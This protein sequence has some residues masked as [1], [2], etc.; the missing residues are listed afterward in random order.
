MTA[1]LTSTGF[2]AK[3]LADILAEVQA[4]QQATIDPALDVSADSVLGQLNAAVAEKL[5]EQWELA[6]SVYR[7]FD[8]DFASGDALDALGALTGARRIDAVATEVTIT[9]GGT[10]GTSLPIGRAISVVGD[11]ALRFES[12]AG[13]TIGG[14]GTVAVIFRATQ[15]G[16]IAI[17]AG[18]SWQIDTPVSGWS[19]ATNALDGVT[20]RDA[21][22]DAAYRA[23]R[24]QLLQTSGTSPVEAIR[25]DLLGVA[26]VTSCTI[27]ENPTDTTD[28]DGVP[29]HAFEAVVSGGADL[30][31]AT[32]LWL[33]KA[34]GIQ[35]YGTTSQVIQDSQGLSHTMRFS[36]PTAVPIY[37]SATVQ[38]DP[39]TF[40]ADGLDMILAALLAQGDAMAVGADVIYAAQYSPIFSVPGV[41]DVTLLR[42]GTS[43]PPSGTTNITITPRQLATWDSS[44]I[45]ITII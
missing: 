38:V 1:G 22:T 19:T 4:A 12:T 14:G 25:A 2:V 43:G 15:T 3:S 44:R 28:V 41:L 26:G 20:G 35:T 32:Q 24:E 42:T 17:Y 18:T 13:A 7:A 40:P 34:A 23:R 5:S 45:A 29:P 21:E 11:P 36:R 16:P 33:S 37:L 6:S 30:D 31:I 9:C 27:F 8:P 39:F 10:P